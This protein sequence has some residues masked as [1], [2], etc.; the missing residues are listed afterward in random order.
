MRRIVS[1]ATPLIYLA[2]IERLD[3]L[4]KVFDEVIIPEEVSREAVD[5]GKK[6]KVRDAFIIGQAIQE[7]WLRVRKARMITSPIKLDTGELAV[8][9]LAKQMGV[10]EVLIDET[11]ARTAAK[12]V[13]L[14]ARGTIFVLLRALEEKLIDLEGF[15]ESM[16]KLIESG[17][18]L[19]EE[20]YVEAIRN[21]RRIVRT[22][23]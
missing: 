9:S 23:R 1:N 5:T 10:K 8:I 6:L 21:A 19:R 4:R 2:K 12:L 22:R 15:L 11:P 18:R 13:G 16:G 14:E 20:I 7:G 17:F 3:L